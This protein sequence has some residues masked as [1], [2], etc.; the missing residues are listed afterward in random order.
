MRWNAT[1]VGDGFIVYVVRYRDV[2]D[3]IQRRSAAPEGR[4]TVR[5]E[6]PLMHAI[7]PVTLPAF[8]S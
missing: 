6:V 5:V 8:L 7:P 3:R 4:R 1:A 2:A